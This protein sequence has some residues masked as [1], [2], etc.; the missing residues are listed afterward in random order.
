M[1][2]TMARSARL[3]SRQKDV[4]DHFMSLPWEDIKKMMA[5][6]GRIADSFKRGFQGEVP[7]PRV[8]S[9]SQ[10]QAAYYAGKEWAKK[11]KK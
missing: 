8:S 1:E 6:H 3:N 7:N 4:F 11:K 2:H 9:G 10:S 5:I